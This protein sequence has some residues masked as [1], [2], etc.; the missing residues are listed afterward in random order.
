MTI[1]RVIEDLNVLLAKAEF[2]PQ[3]YPLVDHADLGRAMV[4]LSPVAVSEVLGYRLGHAIGVPLARVEGIMISNA[5]RLPLDRVSEN[6]IGIFIEYLPITRI[7]SL[8]AMC[9]HDPEVAAAALTLCLFDRHEWGQF[10][11]RGERLFFFDLE[12]IL[13]AF[14]L[15]VHPDEDARH[16]LATLERHSQSYQA[17]DNDAIGEIADLALKY[18]FMSLVE[19][20]LRRLQRTSRAD[21][22]ALFGLTPHPMADTVARLAANALCCRLDRACAVWKRL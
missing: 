7:W 19:D 14:Q 8:E 5:T 18:G 13:P 21:W 15:D 11:E 20:H 1:L 9:A 3:D 16:M 22:R 10:G 12:R 6:R 17:G 4:K 2:G